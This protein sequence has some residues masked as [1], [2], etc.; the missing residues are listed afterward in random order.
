V[1]GGW[2][3]ARAALAA[4]DRLAAAGGDVAFYRR[5]IASARFFGDHVVSSAPGLLTAILAGG[6]GAL[7][8]AAED[9]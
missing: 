1:H 7:A 3:L 9:F 8:L 6:A 2:Q 5:K 4:D